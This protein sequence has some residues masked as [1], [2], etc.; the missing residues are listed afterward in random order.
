MK[1]RGRRGS[2][3]IEDRRG[4]SAG[5]V[6]GV[7]GIGLIAVLLIG[8]LLGI[9]VTPLLNGGVTDKGTVQG[10]GELTDRPTMKTPRTATP[11]RTARA[12]LR[13]DHDTAAG[14]GGLG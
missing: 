10:G 3:N 11:K 2:D 12:R 7:G 6:G 8:Y 1:W 13:S 4:M 9:D 5:R 14:A